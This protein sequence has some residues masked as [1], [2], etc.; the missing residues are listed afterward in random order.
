MILVGVDAMGGDFAPAE[1]VK[2]VN[3]A[4]A[5]NKEIEINL[6]GDQDQILKYL[7][8][9]ERVHIIHTPDFVDMGEKDPIKV[10]RHNKSASIILAMN[11]L[12]DKKIDA[13]VSGGPTQVIMVGGY[14]I[15]K[16][17]EGMRRIALAPF[18]PSPDGR[19]RIILDTGGNVTLEPI[20]LVD[21]GRHATIVA[22]T[23][24][25]I[26][27]PKCAL[28]NIGTEPGKGREFDKEAFKL[29]ED[30]K[31]FNFIG[32]IE[33]KELFT[34]E[35]DIILQD[36]WTNNIAIKSLEGTAKTMANVLKKEIMSSL[37]GKIGYLFMRKNLERFKEDFNTLKVGGA[38]ILGLNGI[39]VKS[40]GSSNQETFF[41]AILQAA[42]LV[43]K[44]VLNLINR[45]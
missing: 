10:V 3:L 29:L 32:N 15:V 31:E 30:Q 22:K 14:I 45:Q 19:K 7:I 39:V 41:Q 8:P 42:D 13:L 12:R 18:I 17:A 9:H 37:W 21:F 33:S 1:V 28:L 40:H 24:L 6:Y 36:G 5:K 25:G 38:M 23:L 35:A 26:D 4:I 20:D 43:S 27:N 16:R 2:G 11:D 44:D 34:T